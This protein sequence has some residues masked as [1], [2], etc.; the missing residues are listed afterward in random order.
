MLL[1]GILLVAGLGLILVEAVGFTR[2]GYDADFWKLP[3]DAKLDHV[4]KHRRDWWW[5]SIWSLV[6]IFL[7]TAGLAGLTQ[8]ISADGEPVLAFV[9]FGGYLVALFAWVFALI[10]QA[11]TVSRAATE[12]AETG[13]TP[14]WI[15]PFWDAGYLA[16][17]V[18]IVGANIAYAV[19]GIAI[20]QSGVVAA[21]A[22]WATIG[23]GVLI[24]IAVLLIRNGF[25][26]LA[27][28]APFV[29]GIALIIESV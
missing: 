13:K 9:S 2:G 22:G 15:H 14:S 26:Q 12:R 6:G 3:L 16:E 8:L 25:P 21:W 10:A 27:E 19:V 17:G 7:M 29:L 1:V 18:W 5:I 4:A 24:P 11:A 20:L 28:V 23:L